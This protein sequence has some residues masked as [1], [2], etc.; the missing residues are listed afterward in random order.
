MVRGQ[1]VMY[2]LTPL[3]PRKDPEFLLKQHALVLLGR[4]CGWLEISPPESHR[5]PRVAKEDFHLP[6]QK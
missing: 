1:R 5:I 6:V 4:G 2:Q 3:L